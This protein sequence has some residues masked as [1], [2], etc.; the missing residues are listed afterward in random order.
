MTPDKVRI[1]DTTLRDGEQSPGINLNRAEKL[2]IARQLARL[3]VDVIEAGFPAASEGDLESVRAIAREVKGPI[4]AGLAR[5]RNE[6]IMAAWEGVRHAERPRIHTFIATSDIHLEH[7]LRMSR[8][9]VLEEVRR[10]VTLARS[11]TDDVEF[12]AEDA[13]RSDPAFLAQVLRLAVECGARTLNVPDTVGYAVPAEFGA[14]LADIMARV[15]AGRDVIWSV[16]CH[17]DLGLAVANSLEAVRCGARQVECTVNG[18]GERAGNAAMEEI[19]MALRVRRGADGPDTTLDTT[20]FQSLSG[21]VSRLTGFPVPPNKAI[22]GRNAFAHEAGIHQ[23]GVL[24]HRSTYEI[25][26]AED[27]GAPS[28]RLVLGKHSGRHAFASRIEAMGYALEPEAVEELFVLFKNLCDRKEMVT[29][30]DLEA[31]IV[32]EVLSVS[33]QKRLVLK[34]YMVQSAGRDRATATVTLMDGDAEKTDAAT[35]NGPVDA[36][37]SAVKRIMS[38]EPKLLSYRIE[39]VTERADAMGQ[40]SLSIS[41]DGVSAAGRG[42]STDVIEASLKAYVNAL[43]RVFQ[44]QEGRQVARAMEGAC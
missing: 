22:V 18:L 15:D 31:L 3:G 42:A 41:L 36:V 26:K 13:S 34:D 17:D 4:V 38:L 7:K 32:D 8:D 19:V 44:I 39:A 23:H 20:V 14:F 25:M 40:A 28:S 21:L 12:S 30:D 35:G 9:E 27:V 5:T 1:F 37:F 16:H 29:D 6:D 24:R 10:A 33:S 43:N 2:Q 11:L